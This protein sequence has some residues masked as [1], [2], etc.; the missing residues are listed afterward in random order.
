MENKKS[1]L[2]A[3]PSAIIAGIIIGMITYFG[4]N[5]GGYKEYQAQSKVV[6]TNIENLNEA[7]GTA[8]TYAATINSP[9]IKQRTLE[10]LGIDWNVGKLDSKLEIKP[11]ENTSII[12]I[13]VTD[14]N[15]LRAEDIA[16][17]YADYTVRVINNI[18]NS[19]AKV[20]EYSYGS[21][22]TIDNTLRYALMTGGI[23][24]ILWTVLRMIMINSY[25]NKIAKNYTNDK[26]ETSEVR[27]VREVEEKPAKKTFRSSKK[28]ATKKTSK[29][30]STSF[31]SG[32]TKVIDG[33]EV[34]KAADLSETSSSKYEVLGRIPS[35][36]KGELDV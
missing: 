36:D 6:T 26:N 14:T 32:S 31:E 24:F 33:S 25:N 1:L 5:F 19:G 10:T 3:I 8:A 12:D 20:M 11:I 9:K 30:D 22:T 18:Y 28:E 27:E 35:Y 15:K 4:L 16:D 7:S 34:K 21:A 29:V 23:G 2:S 13:V 17:Q